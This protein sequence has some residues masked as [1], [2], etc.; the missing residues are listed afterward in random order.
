MHRAKC[1]SHNATEWKMWRVSEYRFRTRLRNKIN[2][3]S[4]VL[5]DVTVTRL[6]F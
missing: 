2:R 1:D 5:S 6:Y 3:E 4:E